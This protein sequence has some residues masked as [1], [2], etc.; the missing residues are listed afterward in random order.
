MRAQRAVMVRDLVA[1]FSPDR[2]LA[3]PVHRLACEQGCRRA[4][5]GIIL[6]SRFPADRWPPIVAVLL[7]G[8]RPGYWPAAGQDIVC[9]AASPSN[10]ARPHQP[11][12]PPGWEAGRQTVTLATWP[13]IVVDHRLTL[14]PYFPDR[15]I[16]VLI[17]AVHP[18]PKPAVTGMVTVVVPTAELASS[19]VEVNAKFTVSA[20]MV[21]LS[22]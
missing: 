4:P 7:K 21:V 18:P 12:A 20:G 17:L 14:I 3:L 8:E 5:S 9:A 2:R 11:S 6:R 22:S 1:R 15:T 16:V 19:T 10:A 13:V